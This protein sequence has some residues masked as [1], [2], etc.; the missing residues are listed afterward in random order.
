MPGTVLGEPL[1]I[2]VRLCRQALCSLRGHRPSA[3]ERRV[4]GMGLDAEDKVEGGAHC[5]TLGAVSTLSSGAAHKEVE[6]AMVLACRL[7]S[8]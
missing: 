8:R 1:G 7:H 4:M 5:K 3:R 6:R 2:A